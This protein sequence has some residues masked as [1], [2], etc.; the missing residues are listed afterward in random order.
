MNNLY[1]V[2]D[3]GTLKVKFLVAKYVPGQPMETVH[4][5]TTHTLLGYGTKENG[6]NIKD[7]YLEQTVQE[8]LRCK[9]VMEEMG[10]TTY[11]AVSTHALREA[12]NREYVLSNVLERT[13]I[14][15]DNISQEE[16]ALLFL[17]AFMKSV[18]DTNQP[19][20]LMDAGSGSVQVIVGTKERMH[21]MQLLPTGT[22]SLHERLTHTREY[23]E[24]QTWDDVEQMASLIRE[25]LLPVEGHERIPLVFGSSCIIDLL[26]DLGIGVSPYE[27]AIEGHPVSTSS[28]ALHAFIENTLSLTYEEFKERFGYSKGYLWAFLNVLTIAE[29]FSSPVIIPSNVNIAQGLVYS[30]VE[31]SQ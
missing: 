12:R 1:G 29:H 28:E 15:I 31:R 16:E 11:R 8:L 20:V 26:R 10:V 22:L 6:G 2:I 7:E 23:K 17:Q 5:E 21:F 3:I 24:I 14:S 13:G 19:Y 25:G 4:F 30:M 9:K 27:A 18:D